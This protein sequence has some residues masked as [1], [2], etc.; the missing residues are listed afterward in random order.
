VL[1]KQAQVLE[2]RVVSDGARQVAL[3]GD[4]TGRWRSIARRSVSAIDGDRWS[5]SVWTRHPILAGEDV[6]NIRV[7]PTLIGIP[8]T[9][10]TRPN[11]R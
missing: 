4:P 8:M 7:L 11:S 5:S 9:V 6:E 2:T 1:R 3:S 10:R